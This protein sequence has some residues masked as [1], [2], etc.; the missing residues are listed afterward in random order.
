LNQISQQAAEAQPL[1]LDMA[2]SP[3]LTCIAGTNADLF[4]I[5]LGMYVKQGAKI[6]DVTYG[7]GVFWRNVDTATY[8][9]CRSDIQTGVDFRHLPYTDAS[10]DAVVLDPPYMNGGANVKDSINKCYKND[11]NMSHENVMALYL[12][13]ILEARR[14]LV[15]KGILFVKCQPAVAD[16]K[17]KMTHVQIVTVF[18]MIG[19]QIEDE[20]VLRQTVVPLMRHKT[21]QHA[22]KNHSYLLV[23]RRV[24]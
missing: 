20:F 24:R 18:P 13:G 7:N 21:Q 5:A 6:A 10:F 4:P 2:T 22:R 17:Q 3:V 14:V 16:H 23:A 11:G 8:N 9:L 19:F 1:M 12:A 15:R